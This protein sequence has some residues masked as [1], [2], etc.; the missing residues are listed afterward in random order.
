M[1]RLIFYGAVITAAACAL[2][3]YRDDDAEQATGTRTMMSG[4]CAAYA[5]CIEKAVAA[6]QED[7]LSSGLGYVYVSHHPSG[8]GGASVNYRCNAPEIFGSSSGPASTTGGRSPL[9]SRKT[10]TT[11]S[12]CTPED[13]AE[14]KA[15]KVS[16]SAINAACSN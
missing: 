5:D 10:P 14:M 1:R 13:V 8:P 12:N 6:A 16:E 3:P 4:I 7:C 15:A 11:Q 9:R 2:R